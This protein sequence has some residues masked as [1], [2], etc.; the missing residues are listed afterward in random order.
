MIENTTKFVR[1]YHIYSRNSCTFLTKILYLNLGSLIYARNLFYLNKS[2]YT[3]NFLNIVLK[4]W[5]TRW[6]ELRE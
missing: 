4:A 6:R 5:I 3:G 2:G 1:Y